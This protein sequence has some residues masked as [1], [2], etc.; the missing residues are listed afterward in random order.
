M[1]VTP[2][3]GGNP[4]RYS[5]EIVQADSLGVKPAQVLESWNVTDAAN[6]GINF[7]GV[8]DNLIAVG[9][10]FYATYSGNGLMPGG[11]IANL[12]DNMG[13]DFPLGVVYQR[14]GDFPN[15]Q[16]LDGGGAN[17]ANS[18]DPYFVMF[19]AIP[20]PASCVLFAL[21]LAGFA[22]AAWRHSRR[23]N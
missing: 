7:L 12:S 16:L 23:R 6:S 21:G 4:A 15:M 11:T 8:Y 17:V 5:E 2:A 18:I 22:A 20:E 10:K 19:Q 13:S 14:N 9:D 3:N 1:R